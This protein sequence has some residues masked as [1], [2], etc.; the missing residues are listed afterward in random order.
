[1][2]PVV[3]QGSEQ[4]IADLIAQTERGILVNRA[5]YVRYVNPRTLEVTGYDTGWHILD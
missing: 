2:Y 5:W 1:M 3:M 4:S